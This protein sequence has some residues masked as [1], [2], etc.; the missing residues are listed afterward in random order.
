M[1]QRIRGHFSEA[2]SLVVILEKPTVFV[3]KM[4]KISM[5]LGEEGGVVRKGEGPSEEL[6]MWR[7]HWSR[8]MQSVGAFDELGRCSRRLLDSMAE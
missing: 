6:Y 8:C 2:Q 7:M 3:V 1:E 5:E 4:A